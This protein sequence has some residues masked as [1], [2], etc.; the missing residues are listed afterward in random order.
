MLTVFLSFFLSWI[1]HLLPA[2]L[3]ENGCAEYDLKFEQGR[4]SLCPKIPWRGG[5]S[6]APITNNHKLGAGVYA[7]NP[8]T[9]EAGVGGSL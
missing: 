9:Q 1:P 8:N 2:V 6:P 4:V 7:F 5:H 3:L